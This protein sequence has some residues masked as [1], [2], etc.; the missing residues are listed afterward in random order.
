MAEGSDQEGDAHAITSGAEL[1]RADT[2]SRPRVKKMGSNRLH[3]WNLV[4]RE[5]VSR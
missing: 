1:R 3:T 5:C 2:L 4:S